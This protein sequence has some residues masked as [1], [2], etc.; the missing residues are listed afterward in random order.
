MRWAAARRR[1]APARSGRETTA[2]AERG[3]RRGGDADSDRAAAA[4]RSGSVPLGRPS[5]GGRGTAGRA[6]G[7]RGAQRGTGAGDHPRRRRRAA[8]TGQYSA[9]RRT[10]SAPV[11]RVPRSRADSR[12]GGSTRRRERTRRRRRTKAAAGAARCRRNVASPSVP[13]T[14][15]R[16]T[17]RASG[18]SEAS[19]TATSH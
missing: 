6:A 14:R 12:R 16:A 5:G 2:L 8:D 18:R 10:Y 9:G 1:A 15:P 19:T 11:G 4:G 13:A 7:R 3:S 17:W